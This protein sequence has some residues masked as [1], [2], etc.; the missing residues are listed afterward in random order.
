M[1]RRP[2][3]VGI[4]DKEIFIMC[5]N[6][7]GTVRNFDVLRHVNS[8]KLEELRDADTYKDYCEDLWRCA[9]QAGT[10]EL[11]L[12][13]FA[14]ELIDD[15]DVDNDPEAFPCKDD[16]GLMYLTEEEREAADKFMLDK[17]GIEVG[18]WECSG[19]YNPNTSWGSG[20][21]TFEKFDYVFDKELAEAYYATLSK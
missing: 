4:Y 21:S 13:D 16:S 2:K 3:A 8:D 7:D 15:A 18:T 5:F 10:T 14:Q 17:Y 19:S 11:G 6:E 1:K 9:V 20:E 12:L